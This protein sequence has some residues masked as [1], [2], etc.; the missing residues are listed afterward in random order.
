[1]NREQLLLQLK[2]KAAARRRAERS[3]NQDPTTFNDV[4][5]ATGDAARAFNTGLVRPFDPTGDARQF[6]SELPVVGNAVLAPGQSNTNLAG[7]DRSSV[8]DSAG[9]L[10]G[11]AASFATAGAVALGSRIGQA[12]LR[13][14]SRVPKVGATISKAAGDAV[15]FAKSNPKTAL[16]TESAAGGAAG[17]AGAASDQATENGDLS[18]GQRFAARLAS[19][20]TAGIATAAAPGVLVNSG[21]RAAE[22]IS[23]TLLPFT[24]RGGFP[25]AAKPT[26]QRAADPAASAEL[27]RNAPE[28]VTPARATGD[29][30]LMAQEARIL[31][32]NPELNLQV[33][34]DLQGAQQRVETQFREQFGRAPTPKEREVAL[35]NLGAAP[36]ARV[37][38]GATD[39]MIQAAADSFRSAYQ[40]ARGVELDVSDLGVN[41]KQ[42][43][44]D[45]ELIAGNEQRRQAA[46]F[47]QNQLKNLSKNRL[48]ENLTLGSGDL[49]DLRSLVR[50]RIRSLST[51]GDT[52]PQVRSVLSNAE[53]VLT[54]TLEGQLSD[55]A[56]ATLRAADRQ[57]RKFKIIEDAAL[58][59]GEET[60]TPGQVSSSIRRNAR[61]GSEFARGGDRELRQAALAQRSTEEVLGNPDAASRMVRDLAP[62][63][64]QPIKADFTQTL[65]RRANQVDS[66]TGE[67]IL[68]GGRLKALLDDNAEVA[69]NLGF[70]G[71]EI[72]RMDTIADEL[73]TIQR[74]SPQAVDDLFID[75]PATVMELVAAITGSKS[76]Q[77]IAG[78]GLGSSLVLAQFMSNRARNTLADLTRSESDRIMKRAVTDKELFSALLTAETASD[79]V[80]RQAARKVGGFLL[81]IGN[82]EIRGEEQPSEAAPNSSNAGRNFPPQQ[83]P[84]P[85]LLSVPQSPQPTGLLQ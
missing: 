16:A 44:D 61:S 84:T 57:F 55:D 60:L 54:D 14:L 29:P 69:R 64:L 47:L 73:I 18:D 33:T 62:D 79:A 70:S 22:G 53:R 76:G 45:P 10:A 80:K 48:S 11:E 4:L 67:Q 66:Q 85:G 40:G 41:L 32:D 7:E 5:D 42:A 39:D 1:M 77:R 9:A 24:E 74:K 43:I 30:G 37:E 3:R 21:R 72:S 46:A 71:D 25:R 82:D 23:T 26:Q 19:E 49:L 17:A 52:G 15:K 63:Q 75:G 34:R 36:G 50:S 13:L 59:S 56:L 81:A 20:L 8:F 78:G 35:I 38:A 27:S 51:T 31:A 68:A 65:F 58:R 6:I 28:G 83:A 12:G 2:L